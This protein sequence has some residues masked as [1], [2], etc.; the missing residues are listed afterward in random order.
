MISSV[1][2]AR[3]P[4][5]RGNFPKKTV[6]KS[7]M[8]KVKTLLPANRPPLRTAGHA[9]QRLHRGASTDCCAR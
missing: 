1:K 7:S 2:P 9:L 6:F 4:R 5:L 3:K 8:I